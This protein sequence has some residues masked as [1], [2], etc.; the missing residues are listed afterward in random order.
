MTVGGTN[1]ISSLNAQTFS[2]NL[3]ENPVED[4]AIFSIRSVKYKNGTLDY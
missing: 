4:L 2:F 3:V 1:S